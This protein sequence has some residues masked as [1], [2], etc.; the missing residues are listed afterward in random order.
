LYY[1]FRLVLYLFDQDRTINKDFS[2]EHICEKKLTNTK[3]SIFR[4]IYQTGMPILKP[5]QQ[6]S[7]NYL[8]SCFLL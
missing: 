7:L 5:R 1:K 8:S 4:N 6:E 3:L 2:S